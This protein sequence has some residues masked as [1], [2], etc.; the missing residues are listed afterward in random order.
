[1]V[2]GGYVVPKGGFSM[3]KMLFILCIALALCSLLGC[4]QG[5]PGAAASDPARVY[6]VGETVKMGYLEL[7]VTQV[8]RNQGIETDRP[9]KEGGEFVVITISL[10]NN[11]FDQIYYGAQYFQLLD[12][13]GQAQAAVT[14]LYGEMGDLYTGVVTQF[15]PK[16]GNLIFEA[17][18]GAPGL[19]L[20][21]TGEDE[22]YTAHFQI[23]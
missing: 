17:P 11:G 16:T 2:P 21:Y 14:S 5:T 4:S 8:D 15:T 18:Q 6:P 22:K 1:M 3:R 10:A 20:V 13:Q 12:G 7:T 19:V 9:E 23:S